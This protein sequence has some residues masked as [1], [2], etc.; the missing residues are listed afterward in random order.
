MTALA[1]T[2]VQEAF[3]S[4]ILTLEIWVTTCLAFSILL[5]LLSLPTAFAMY[6][7]WD[8]DLWYFGMA[9]GWAVNGIAWACALAW[10]LTDVIA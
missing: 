9:F 5:A 3:N 6:R 8:L 7:D 4:P 2:S 1:L 10:W